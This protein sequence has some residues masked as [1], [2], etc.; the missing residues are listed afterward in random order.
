MSKESMEPAHTTSP[1]GSTANDEN[2]NLDGA[3]NVRKFRYLIKSQALT[4]PSRLAVNRTF[5][6]LANSQADT[7]PMCSV[8]V[9][10][11]KPELTSQT[12]ILPSS[13]AVMMRWPSG[14]YAIVF[15]ESKCP[16]CF[17]MYDSD[18]HSQTNSW[19]S[20]DA[21]KASHSPVL[22]MATKSMSFCDMLRFWICAKLGSSW[23]KK[24]PWEKPV[25]SSLDSGWN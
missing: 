8:N 23:I 17:R 19:P 6:R 16:C 24:R 7:P 20:L 22:F 5:P 9:T 14:E 11:Q 18:C 15:I 3:V 2:D 13:A 1:L 4:E 25:T 10:T 21:P 12:L